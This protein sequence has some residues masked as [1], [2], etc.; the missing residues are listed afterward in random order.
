MSEKLLSRCQDSMRR[1]ENLRSS[2]AKLSPKP[3]IR[4]KEI[5]GA[6]FP[7]VAMRLALPLLRLL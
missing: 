3:P 6:R 5:G 1:T 4:E 2:D 7:L